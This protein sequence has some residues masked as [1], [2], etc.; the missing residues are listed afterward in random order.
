MTIATTYSTIALIGTIM[1]L[2]KTKHGK[3]EKRRRTMLEK[4]YE[5]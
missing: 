1:K 3:M 4:S 2:I 5:E